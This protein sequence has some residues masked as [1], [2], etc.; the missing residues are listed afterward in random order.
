ME[1]YLIAST[2]FSLQERATKKGK[3]YDVCFRIIDKDG[4]DKQKYLCGYQTKAL[5]KQAYA[6]F[7]TQY[8]ELIKFKH[9]TMRK[10]IEDGKAEPALKELFP[11]YLSSLGN[12]NKDSSI[13]SK[14]S[15]SGLYI[16]PQL[17][18]YKLSQLNKTI[19]LEWQDN[20]WATKNPK[21]SDYYSYKYLS[22][23][24][25][26]L[27]SFLSWCEERYGYKNCLREVKK[28]KRRAPKTVMKFW[29]R[30]EFEKF[31][32]AVDNQTYK[33]I[34]T[35]MFFTGRRKGE[36]LALTT[37]DVQ[38]NSIVFSK[39]CSRRT[40]DGSPY[41]ITSTKN[42]KQDRT[43]ICETLQSALKEYK[44]QSPFFFGGKEPIHENTVSHAF[45]RYISKAEV[46]RIRMH[47]LRHSFVSMC[48]HLGASV[49]VVADLIGDTV[50]QILKTYG[51]LYNE[52]KY[53]IIQKIN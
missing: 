23:I 14:Q 12:Q 5:A 36:I 15:V 29:T 33:T 45:D 48:I 53:E 41:K 49:Y 10:N 16:L 13:Y 1:K 44:P 22:N 7:V 9:L 3:V 28:P 43:P 50:E 19:L 20:I 34:F 8:C 27:S 47:D 51:H 39:T 17:G 24:R 11:L 46:K 37:D 2:K 35:M 52:D 25:M 4:K 6:D 38:N 30:D 32:E 42:E 26:T 21:T 40:L 18:K 31:I